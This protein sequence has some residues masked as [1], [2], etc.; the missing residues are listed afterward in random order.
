MTHY[1]KLIDTI[2]DEIY[3]VWTEISD[4][5]NEDDQETI[6][7]TAQRILEHVEEFQQK[8]VILNPKPQWR[9]SD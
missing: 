2:I 6:K 1:D 9:A 7:E 4:W 5:D 3:Y 8:R